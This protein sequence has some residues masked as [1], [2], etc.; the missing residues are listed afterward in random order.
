MS[1]NATHEQQKPQEQT[2]RAST[3]IVHW[4]PENATEA[5]TLAKY[6]GQSKLVPR[7]LENVADIFVTIAAGRDFG[8]SP[9]QSMR[10][11]HVVEGKPSLSAD[12]MVGIAKKA[13]ICEWFR[14]VESSA[15][16][17]TYETKRK[18]DPAPVEM[19]FTIEEAQ[20]AGLLDKKGPWKSYPARMLRN[21]C[22]SS[23]CK[24]VYEELFFGVYEESE[25]AE[26]EV[27][28]PIPTRLRSAPPAPVD[29]AHSEPLP[30]RPAAAATPA[31]NG[32]EPAKEAIQ[33]PRPAADPPQGDPVSD[34]DKLA[35]A[36]EEAQTLAGLE[37]LVPDLQRL[38][39]EDQRAL[40][41]GFDAKRASLA[42]GQP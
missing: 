6:Y 16:V 4:E 24:E 19:S 42:K 8:W 28:G 35:A 29:V 15:R 14:L 21:R 17:A 26:I 3:A 34:A 39:R 18:G 32:T 33:A 13:D 1:E 22:K 7:A 10:G 40:K 30:A 38:S 31:Q 36:I 12:A 11:I 2:A 9:M 5:W 25:A 37:K 20:A 27:N 23:L 41:P